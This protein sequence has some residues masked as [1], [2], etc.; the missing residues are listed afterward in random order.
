MENVTL[1]LFMFSKSFNYYFLNKIDCF[2]E[3]TTG[4]NSRLFLHRVHTAR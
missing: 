4:E 1:S 3:E 2:E